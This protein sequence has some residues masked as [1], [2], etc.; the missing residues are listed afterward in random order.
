MKNVKL[1]TKLIGAFLM[2]AAI[3]LLIG[4]IGATQLNSVGGAGQQL[5]EEKVV[6]MTDVG[7]L[8]RDFLD[9]RIAVVYA[10]FNKFSLGNDISGVVD[11]L[12]KRDEAGLALVG[13]VTKEII[14]PDQRKLYEGFKAELG[15]YLG[16]RDKLIQAAIAGNQADVVSILTEAKEERYES[17]PCSG[18]DDQCQCRPRQG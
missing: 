2:L 5:Y 4:V 3:G 18:K 14:D 6:L 16:L 7:Q 15:T 11:D 12:K 8:N 17:D 9:M 1:G 10:L 13:K